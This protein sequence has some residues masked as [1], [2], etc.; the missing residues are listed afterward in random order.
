MNYVKVNRTLLICKDR[1][2]ILNIPKIMKSRNNSDFI[3]VIGVLIKPKG[4]GSLINKSFKI[5]VRNCS[6]KCIMVITPPSLPMDR[7]VQE[8][9]ALSKVCQA[10][11]LKD[12]YN[13]VLKK[14]SLKNSKISKKELPLS[15]RPLICKFTMRS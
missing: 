4:Q 7:P 15:L 6:N 13:F 3:D 1:L 12:C 10:Y 2:S 9:L 14:F 11:S 8:S 5:L